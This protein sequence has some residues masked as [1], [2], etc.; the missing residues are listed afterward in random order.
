MASRLRLVCL[1]LLFDMD[2]MYRMLLSLQLYLM[3]KVQIHKFRL[4][5]HT[6]RQIH[7]TFQLCTVVY[8]LGIVHVCSNTR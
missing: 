2:I 8:A 3:Y 1:L 7:N 4:H 5:S 6:D